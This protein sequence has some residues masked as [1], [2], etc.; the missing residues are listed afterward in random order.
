MCIGYFSCRLVPEAAR[1]HNFPMFRAAAT[2]ALML[3]SAQFCP[4]A[5]AAVLWSDPGP[6]LAHDTGPGTNIFGGAVKRDVTA[7]DV[8]YFKFQ[9]DPLSD[10]TTEEYFAAFQLFEGDQER[11]AVGNSPK[12]WSYSAFNTLETGENNQVAGD[13]DLRSSRPEVYGVGNVLRYELPRRGIHCTIVFKVRFV[14]GGDDIVSVWMNPDLTK[15]ATEESQSDSLTTNFKARAAF[16]QI[17]LRHGGLAADGWIFS[18]MAIAT[19]FDD[20]VVVR[21]WQTWWFNTLVALALLIGGGRN[22]PHRRTEK[23]STAA[24]AR[25]TGERA[26][27]GTGAHRPGLAR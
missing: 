4:P 25:R 2:L 1:R 21:F 8:L 14:P 23:I 12:A 18:D 27:T 9:V 13:M 24:P 26:G 19:S 22:G 7:S 17:R 5:R 20:F 16:N 10:G 15:G 11:L 3:L 6:R